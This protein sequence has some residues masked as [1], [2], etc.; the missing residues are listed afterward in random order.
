M[1]KIYSGKVEKS[2]KTLTKEH[3]SESIALSMYAFQYKVSE[4]EMEERKKLLDDHHILGIW[5]NDKLASKL[6]MLNFTVFINGEEWS[7]GGIAG[8]ATYPE[9]R[10]LGHVKALI[11]QSLIEMK[12][13]GQLFSFL[14]PFDIGFYRKFG[15]EIF[16]ENKKLTIANKDLSMIGSISG[17]I[18]RINPQENDAAEKI[19][20]KYIQRY[21]GGLVRDK[22]WWE[23]SIYEDEEQYAIFEDEEGNP[24]GYIAYEIKNRLMKVSEYIA[25]TQEARVQLWNFICQHDSML[26]TVELTTANNDPFPYFLKQP[27]QKVEVYPYF[28]GRIVD[29][30]RC[31]Q[32]YKFL[33][34]TNDIVLKIKDEFAQWNNGEFYLNGESVQQTENCIELS[35]NALSAIL[36][37]YKRPLELYE[38]GEINGF[39]KDIE[40]FDQYVPYQK[41]AFYDF[42]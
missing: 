34:R 15:W 25:L 13:K 18:N 31:L 16:S 19:Y 3:Y 5:E 14:H 22:S 40:A 36:I 39:E 30:Q 17:K 4:H 11:S 23:R 2:V 42:F 32:S 38:L 27:K 8:V 9:Y 1:K 24:Q 28:M 10:R 35:I 26:N 6:H 37:G 12:E 41:T 20:S 29:V 33:N 7:M 21:S